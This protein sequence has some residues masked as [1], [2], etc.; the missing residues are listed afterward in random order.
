LTEGNCSCQDQ[1]DIPYAIGPIITAKEARNKADPI[2]H[3][4]VA[5]ND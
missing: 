4:K 1:K 5:Q 3:L 2:V